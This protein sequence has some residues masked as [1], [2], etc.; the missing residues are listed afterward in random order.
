[1]R[2]VL[3]ISGPNLNMLGRREPE[4]YGTQTLGDIEAAVVGRA[5][6]LGVS[7]SFFQSNHEGA[8]ID[9]I[10]D[11]VDDA[12]GIVIN[13]GALTH[14][15]YSLRDAIASVDLPTIEV[16]LSNIAKREDFRATSVVAPVCV[17]QISGLGADSYLRGLEALC[18][19]LEGE[20]R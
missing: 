3:V 12:D 8:L 1:M 17:G 18:D 15:S 4:I 7:V 11:A 2:R 5:E 9:R 14:Y 6:E 10:Q 16:H 13:P 20:T 19:L